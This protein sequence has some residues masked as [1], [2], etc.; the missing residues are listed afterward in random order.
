MNINAQEE[1]I[2]I[3]P[4]DRIKEEKKARKQPLTCPNKV[5][6]FFITINSNYFIGDKTEEEYKD[7]RKKFTEVLC[8]ALPHFDD[9]VDFKTSKLGVK[10]GYGE[11]DAKEVLT[12]GDR[13]IE[14]ALKYV[15]E[16]SPN[17]KRLHAHILFYM[18]KKGVD[19]KINIPAIKKYMEEKLG[20]SCYV[21]YKLVSSI[22][23]LEE[24]MRKNPLND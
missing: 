7:Y 11:K 18:R 24:Y 1:T 10:F 17:T 15:L 9:F 16:V 6:T 5:S 22:M 8:A 12:R 14:N 23:S 2:N 20:N 4:E 3:K 21:N 19:T 13:I